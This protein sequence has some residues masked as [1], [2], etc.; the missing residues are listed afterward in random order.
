[1]ALQNKIEIA[2][3]TE[4][5]EEIMEGIEGDSYFLLREIPGLGIC[6]LNR[7]MFTV[8]LVIGLDTYC[9]KYRYCYPYESNNLETIKGDFLKWNG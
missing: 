3:G 5:P 8:G 6:G 9:Y 2:E 7:F 1:M 4:V